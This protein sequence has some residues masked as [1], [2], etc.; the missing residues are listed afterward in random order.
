MWET[1]IR[2]LPRDCVYLQHGAKVTII[3]S[4]PFLPQDTLDPEALAAALSLERSD[5]GVHLFPQSLSMNTERLGVLLRTWMYARLHKI[6]V[7]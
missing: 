5:S 3:T 4:T 6:L 7:R 1:G 2:V